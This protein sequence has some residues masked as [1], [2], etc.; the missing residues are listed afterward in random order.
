MGFSTVDF[1]TDLSLLISEINGKGI[2]TIA[3]FWLS[4]NNNEDCSSHFRDFYDELSGNW[5]VEYTIELSQIEDFNEIYHNTSLDNFDFAC[6]EM[7][8]SYLFSLLNS[9]NT[10]TLRNT[11]INQVQGTGITTEQQKKT[12]LINW[13]FANDP[14]GSIYL[15][16]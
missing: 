5:R 8:R 13:Y 9:Q 15:A 11:M 16:T 12:W 2:S 14:M 1:P 6:V 7:G 4:A 3:G 10:T